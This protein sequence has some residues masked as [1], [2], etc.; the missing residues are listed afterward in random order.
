M[1]EQQLRVLI[2]DAVLRALQRLSSRADEAPGVL[3]ISAEHAPDA[4]ALDAHL[5]R[6]FGDKRAYWLPDGGEA[7][8]GA[9]GVFSGSADYRRLLGALPHY[10]AVVLAFPPLG[11]LERIARGDDAGPVERA[12]LKAVLWGRPVTVLLDFEKPRFRRGT[13]FETLCDTLKSIEDMGVSVESL[14]PCRCKKPEEKALVTEA[15]VDD[16]IK[17]GDGYVWCMPGAIV[18]PL[19]R[20]RA[21]EMN[22][23][24]GGGQGG[25][26][27]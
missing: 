8:K 9:H 1:D 17:R 14:V 3:V 27:P 20:D 18:T 10:E 21:R 4:A 16:A 23:V 2:A 22:V 6:T 26:K 19:A 11:M 12:L 24:I 13:F 25:A 5:Q 7:P 15:D